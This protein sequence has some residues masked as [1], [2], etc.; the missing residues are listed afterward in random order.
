MSTLKDALCLLAI[1]V[2]Y[3]IAGHMDYEDA[4]AAQEVQQAS[5]QPDRPECPTAASA[6]DPDR[7]PPSERPDNSSAWLSPSHE[8]CPHDSGGEHARH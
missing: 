4:M 8:R 2:V 1:F 5:M 3:G 6:V 7:L